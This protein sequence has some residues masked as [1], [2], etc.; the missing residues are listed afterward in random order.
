ME[1]VLLVMLQLIGIGF[2]VMQTIIDLG[3]KFPTETPKS[4]WFSFWKTDWDSLGVSGL[5]LILSVISHYV[6]HTYAPSIASYQYF[7]LMSFG[8]SLILG[9]SGQT[10]IYK[11]LG[12]AS[13]AL[14]QKVT[15]KLS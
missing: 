15:D 11:F 8:I 4:V 12:K 14:E 9:Y 13:A 6:I 1:Y 2:H 10:L 5:V 3:N 7:E